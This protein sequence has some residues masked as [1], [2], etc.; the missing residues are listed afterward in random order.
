MLS[1]ATPLSRNQLSIEGNHFVAIMLTEKNVWSSHRGKF[2]H[3]KAGCFQLIGFPEDYRNQQKDM[4]GVED[5]A[6]VAIGN[7]G[8]KKCVAK[9]EHL[10]I[11]QMFF[12]PIEDA[13]TLRIGLR[14]KSPS[15]P[16]NTKYIYP[17]FVFTIECFRT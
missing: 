2:R 11:S 16:R 8:T 10:G 13:G 15:Y 3:N 4:I 5:M 7:Q 9:V 6:T 1:E 14:V 17:P 12:A